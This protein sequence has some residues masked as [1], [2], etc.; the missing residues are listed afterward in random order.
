MT[1]APYRPLPW[2]ATLGVAL[3]ALSA[4]AQI[5]FEEPARLLSS[6]QNRTP[7]EL[8]RSRALQ[9]YGLGIL[10][11]RRGRPSDAAGDYEESARLDPGAAAPRRA[12]VELYLA[13]GRLDDCLDACRRT[14]A[15]DPRD[16]N[17]WYLYA[18]QL[19]ER[20]QAKMAMAVLA[21]GLRQ[22]DLGR[23]R[24]LQAQIALD[25]AGL[26]E[27]SGDWAG[28]IEAYRTVITILTTVL[29]HPADVPE[30]GAIT[31]EASEARASETF[32]RLVHA[33]AQA[34]RYADAVAAFHEARARGLARSGRL[35]Y[36]LAQ[37]YGAQGSPG[38]ALRH[39][40]EYLSTQPAGTEG[41]ELQ[42]ELLRKL[43]RGQ[44]ILP[45]LQKSADRD[46]HNAA[47]HLLLAKA[48]ADGGRAG[49]AETLYRRLADESPGPDTYRG[50]FA[51]YRRG[52]AAQALT[53]LD[54]TIARGAVRDDVPGD[55]GAAIRARAMIE[56]LR[57]DRESAHCIVEAAQAARD[58]HPSTLGL[59]AA[60]AARERESV[61]AE[62][63]FRAFL[64]RHPSPQT[65]AQIYP[66]FLRVLW[67][68]NKRSAVIELCRKG[69]KNPAADQLI[70]QRNLAVALA[71][72]GQA[73]Q[74]LAASDAALRLAGP[75]CRLALAL[76]RVEVLR[77]LGRSV[78]AA[79]EGKALLREASKPA[80][81]R[82]IRYV[83]SGVYS[84]AHQLSQ[85]E[86]QLRLILSTYPDDAPA[87]N[88]LGYLLADEGRAL[89]EAEKL[90]RK[91]IDLDRRRRRAAPRADSTEDVDHA[92]YVDSL[93]WILFRRGHLDEAR[94]QLEKAVSLPDG[95]N[96]PVVWD[97]L[98]DVQARAGRPADARAAWRKALSLFERDGRHRPDEHYRMLRKKLG[99]RATLASR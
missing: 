92:A 91:A 73:D 30:F 85:A 5:P 64:A 56:A 60:L 62:N 81:V 76:T 97:H 72:D 86:E 88:D 26:R 4:A 49:E 90:I 41:Y 12:L 69:L 24:D 63:F 9:L 45:T 66:D 77:A 7:S 44:E 11:E 28:A 29:D 93:G 13:L 61:A 36:Q 16:A 71:L 25:L 67:D 99:L 74:A 46:P 37:A 42:V 22:A 80:E 59:L 96:D 10:H 38:E 75:E 17:I 51:L 52:R 55:P 57:E 19:R 33:Y 34:G 95:A 6:R 58:L 15:L 83:L 18:C 35:S 2:A 14:L 65:E 53:L 98:G 3:C 27:D 89:E 40:D 8:D 54:R 31:H 68:V 43:G 32:E 70:L 21:D 87:C 50:L 82:E 20:G 47:L 39:L 23:R 79:D 84:A 1:H 78:E 48:L 94:R